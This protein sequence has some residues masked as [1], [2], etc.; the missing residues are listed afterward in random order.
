MKTIRL[1]CRNLRHA[2]A[3]TAALTLLV[4]LLAM[5]LFG[6][7][8]VIGSLQNGL[9]SLNARLGADII[10][11]PKTARSKVNTDNLLLTGTTGYFYMKSS[12]MDQLAEI[13]GVEKISGQ[14][15][16][17]SMRADCCSTAIQVIG[18]DQETDF[19]VQPWIA[20]GYGKVL[21]DGEF[22]VGSR[23]TSGVGESIRI[24]GKNCPV[25]ARLASTGTAMDTAVYCTMDTLRMLLE[26][27]KEL[28][29]DLQ[30]GGDPADIIS[31]VYIKVKPDST[32]E[33]VTNDINLHVRKV[34]AA[35][36]KNMLSEI[37]DSLDGVQHV[38]S[39][40]I[41]AIWVLA[42]LVLVLAFAMLAHER[43]GEFAVLR[44]I[45]MSRGMLA[46]TAL[47]ESVFISTIGGVLGIGIGA[48]M[49]CSFGTLI[50]TQLGLP[51]L[52]AGFA[53][54]AVYALMTLIA[55]L[56]IGP[57]SSAWAIL[58]LSRVDTGT[59]LRE[60]S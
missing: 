39:V 9:S 45:G 25:V 48:V 34:E 8:M 3:R 54:I 16:L 5:S 56:V 53:Q 21:G 40:L 27:A 52:M 46:R 4:A 60:G 7:C 20:Q 28:G 50:E 49:I 59:I 14:L 13:E 18:I 36:T 35:S 32:V 6:G 19:T 44:V 57:V 2:S 29:H 10:C 42:F 15:Y 11:I 55:V 38:I 47:M 22:V 43:K 58:R 30:I 51:Y 24:Y 12:T 37:S 31:A 23:V 41:V 17:A 26:A 1:S 33:A